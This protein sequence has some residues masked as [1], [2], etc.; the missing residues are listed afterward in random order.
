M[1]DTD[2]NMTGQDYQ[3]KMQKILDIYHKYYIAIGGFIE[4]KKTFCF[5]QRWEWKK[6]IKVVKNRLIEL[7]IN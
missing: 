6:D 4:D 1:D 2:F 7:Q 3:T 5:C